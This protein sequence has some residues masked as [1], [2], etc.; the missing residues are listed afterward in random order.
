MFVE[1]VGGSGEGAG[2]R[3][4]WVSVV[5]GV[6]CLALRFLGGYLVWLKQGGGII[7]LLGGSRRGAEVGSLPGSQAWGVGVGRR[8][9]R[10]GGIWLCWPDWFIFLALMS[11][12]LGCWLEWLV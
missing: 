5:G 10:L 12:W 1:D 6:C 2:P 11:D 8:N 3:A 9:L 7:M 4:G